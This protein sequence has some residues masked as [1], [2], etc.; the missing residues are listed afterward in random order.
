MMQLTARRVSQPSAAATRSSCISCRRRPS[1]ALDD[2]AAGGAR[3]RSPTAIARPTS[4]PTRSASRWSADDVRSSIDELL[5]MRAI[6]TVAAPP[7]KPVAEKPKRRIPLQTLVLNVT[8][9]CNLSCGYCYEYG[10]DQIVEATTKPRFMNEATAKQSVDFMFAE[11]GDS[12]SVN[13]TFFGGETLL[14][15]KMLQVGARLRPGARRRA[16]QAGEREPHDERDA[17][18]RRGHRL[19][20]RERRRRHGVDRRRARAAGQVPRLLERHGQLRPH[21]PEHQGAARA[22]SPAPGR[23]AR[24]AHR[25]E[26]RRR[27]DLPAPVRGD[28]L[29]GSRLRA[30]DDVVAARVRDR[31]RRASSSCSRGFQ[32][33]RR[34][35]FSTRRSLDGATGSRTCATRS[36]R[37]TRG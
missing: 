15:F 9:K 16:G 4:S 23:R 32:S 6:H 12:P 2:V 8:S 37:F 1:C 27:V 22:A 17:A 30:G 28:R 11:A 18:A 31:G 24:H 19:D 26:P 5:G 34:R 33:A 3:R 14:N 36:R 25:A 13:L 35:S 21:R 20:R 7:P 29:L 10:E